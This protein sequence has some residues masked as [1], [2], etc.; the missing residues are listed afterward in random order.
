MGGFFY[1]Q[2]FL[3]EITQAAGVIKLRELE[4]WVGRPIRLLGGGN[5]M[6]QGHRFFQRKIPIQSFIYQQNRHFRLRPQHKGKY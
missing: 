5:R 4:R 3:T 1:L 2:L 6:Q